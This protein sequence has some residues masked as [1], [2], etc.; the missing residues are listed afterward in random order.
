MLPLPFRSWDRYGKLAVREEHRAHNLPSLPI[1]TTLPRRICKSRNGT[2][3]VMGMKS[4]RN[5]LSAMDLKFFGNLWND[6]I[7]R[8]AIPSESHETI[9][10]IQD[11]RV[12]GACQI[13]RGSQPLDV[14]GLRA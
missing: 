3:A 1:Y 13:V 12:R 7:W 5:I 8:T 9:A 10:V 4:D 6:V 11:A 2:F 14:A